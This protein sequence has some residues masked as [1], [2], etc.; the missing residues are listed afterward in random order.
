MKADIWLEAVN[1][2][3]VILGFVVTLFPA[4]SGRQ[5]VLY[6]VFII[7][8]GG[9]HFASFQAQRNQ[10]DN[11]RRTAQEQEQ[12][13][14]DQNRDLRDQ[15]RIVQDQSR[16]LEVQNQGLGDQLRA[17]RKRFGVPMNFDRQV[18]ENMSIGVGESATV[19]KK[20]PQ[21]KKT[22]GAQ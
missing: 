18:F 9:A 16:S 17:I 8:L 20:T 21:V 2:A 22:P 15:I 14:K 11:E 4:I 7:A 12:I 6:G 19:E 10:V 13:L 5:K 1:V 3:M